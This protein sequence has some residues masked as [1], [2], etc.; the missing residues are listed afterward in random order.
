MTASDG[1]YN[2]INIAPGDY[3]VDIHNDSVDFNIPN[4]I[5]TTNNEPALVT[6]AAGQVISN[7]FNFGYVPTDDDGP[8]EP[9]PPTDDDGPAEPPPPTDDGGT[10]V[11]SSSGTTATPTPEDTSG[12]DAVAPAPDAGTVA[13]APTP[14]DTSGTD[15][16][17]PAPA[18]DAGGGTVAAA[19][20]PEEAT[21]YDIAAITP[22]SY[23]D[24]SSLFIDSIQL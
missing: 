19:P 20:A 1:S 21:A 2:F 3:W 16:E 15:A 22:E 6:I 17:T 24:S 18:P 5:L 7:A 23:L 11:S 13:A 4:Y 8:V 12:T 10:S 9:P 14:E